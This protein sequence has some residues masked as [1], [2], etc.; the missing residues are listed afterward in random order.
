MEKLF[1]VCINY[2]CIKKMNEDEELLLLRRQAFAGN[3][4]AFTL[5]SWITFRI[6]NF[7]N[8]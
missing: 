6:Y 4:N 8:E 2:G 3:K 1:Q 5:L 7:K